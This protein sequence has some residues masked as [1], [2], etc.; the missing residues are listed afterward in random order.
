MRKIIISL[1]AALV[2][3]AVGA[4]S[5][6]AIVWRTLGKEF[7][8]KE[9][10]SA[11]FERKG[12]YPELV[13]KTMKATIKCS[14][15][16]SA[17][18]KV[19]GGN[20][21][22]A[23]AALTATGCTVTPA[24]CTVQDTTIKKGG[25]LTLGLSMIMVEYESAPGKFVVVGLNYFAETLEFINNAP[26]TCPAELT[27]NN[28][29]MLKGNAIGEIKPEAEEKTE[30]KFVYPNPPKTV[31]RVNGACPGMEKTTLKL[32]GENAEITGELGVE[33]EAKPPRTFGAY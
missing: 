6:S 20:P 30:L 29:Y 32:G 18:G 15:V 11:T 25:E 28:P 13:I 23:K 22:T 4:G 9:E 7:L 27:K 16:T 1:C 3:F 31:Y 10:F 33:E 24:E 26:A 21:G 14:G 5:A 12:T 19:E 2:V 17:H 8:A